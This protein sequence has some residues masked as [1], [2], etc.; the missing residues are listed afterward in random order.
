AMNDSTTMPRPIV[1]ADWLLAHLGDPGIRIIDI[2]WQLGGPPGFEAYVAGHIPGAV[3]VDLPQDLAAPTGPGRHPLPS[4]EQLTEVMR[5]VGVGNETDVIV[6]DDAGGSNAARL[7][8]LLRW[9]GHERVAVLDGGV[10][11]WGGPL[12]HG[13]PPP[14]PQGDFSPRDPETAWVV[15][16]D[17]V[18]ARQ[19]NIV[20]LDARHPARYAGISE[21]VD[22]RAGHIPGAR[23]AFWEENLDASGR[24]LSP[25]KLRA[26]FRFLGLETGSDAIV[27][28]GS[29]VTS[30]HLLLAL[31]HAGMPGA[32]LYAGSWSD[33][34][35]RPDS[36]VATDA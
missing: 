19:P 36:P 27:Y 23:S 21:P 22:P 35:S 15:E 24:F 30:C 14:P 33:W 34:C 5:R 17:E 12:E 1:S 13:P 7:W 28:C 32:R 11:S 16:L 8:W 31:E 9:L 2:R 18:A 6:Y 3:F 25:A 10:S 4:A 29:G 20:L 26:R